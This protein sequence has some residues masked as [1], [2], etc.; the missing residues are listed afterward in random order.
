MIEKIDIEDLKEI[1]L[2]AGEAI[3][4][5]YNKD[6]SVDYKDDK[7]PL[8]EADLKS[9]EI[10]CTNLQKLYPNIPIMSEE[11]KQVSYD[12]RKDWE[13]YFCVDPIDGTKEFIKKN[14]EF[15]VNIALI[16]K[17]TPVLG[18]VYAPALKELYSAKQGDGAYLSIVNSQLSIVESKKLP[19]IKEDKS[20][21]NVVASKSHLSEETQEFIDNLALNTE[22]LTLVSKGSSL[23]LCMVATGQADI[24]P[25]LA[26]T[27]E[28][29]TAAADAIVRESGKMTY[30]FHSK[31][32]IENPKV[33]K[34]V[35]Y[36]KADLL[37]PWFV[38]K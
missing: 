11:N 6:F 15:T 27:M 19:Y 23:K 36:N 16:H 21:I 17:N 25:R 12:T 38:V 10:I 2:K 30:Q 18:V 37:N 22:H 32:N 28:W 3:M 13:Y 35:V 1:A 4:Q 29:D 34:P 5:I 14:G 26:P 8:T 7:S 20:T 33:E 24:Y 31:F 9:N